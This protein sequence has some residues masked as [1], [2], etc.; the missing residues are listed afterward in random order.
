MMHV[1]LQIQV[2]SQKNFVKKK[3]KK[4]SK[5][6]VDTILY[7]VVVSI[8]SKLHLANLVAF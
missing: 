1:V 4:K 8:N 6:I 7:H 5:K 3:K 2:F